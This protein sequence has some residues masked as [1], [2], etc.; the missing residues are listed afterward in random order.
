MR[1][2]WLLRVVSLLSVVILASCGG[3][4][5]GDSSLA[6]TQA[7][8]AAKAALTVGY[9]ASDSSANVTQNLTLPATGLDGST[10]SWASSDAAVVTGAGVVT[11]PTTGDKNVT[12]TATI[13][14]GSASDSK[15]F[16]LTVKAQLTE[17]EAVAAAK[18]ALTISY[19]SGDSADCVTQDLTLAPTGIDGSTLTWDSSNPVVVTSAG[20]VSRPVTGEASATLTATITVGAA[21]DTKA[22]PIAVKAQMT[23]V[24]AV[25]AAKAALG[26][27]YASGDS[28]SSVTQ[29]L[30]LPLSGI[31]GSTIGW[32][33]SD[34][35]IVSTAGAVTQ[36]VTGDANVTL[37]ATI[38]VGTASDTKT[39][40]ITVK[41]Q[42]TDAE[43]VAAAKAALAIGYAPGDASTS[44]T[45]NVTLPA[46]GTAGSAISWASSDPAIAADGGVSRPVTGDLPVTLTATISLHAASD[47]KVFIVTVKAQMTDAEAVAAA[48]EALQIGYAEGDSAASVTQNVTLP[49]TGSSAATI[50]WGSSDPTVISSD[51]TIQRPA[52]GDAQVTLTATISSH[53]V[54]D[55]ADFT[56]T[57]KGQISDEDAVAGAKAAL[58][59]GYGAGD[60]AS[61]VTQNVTLPASGSNACSVSWASDAPET[62]SIAGAVTQPESSPAVVTLIATINSHSAS[63][64]KA[65]VLT[66][67]A[68]MDDAAAVAADKTALTIGYG[69]GDSAAHVTG[70][71]VLPTSGTNGSTITWTSDSPEVISI[72]GGVT[73]PN[74]SDANVTMTA[75]ISK[76][77]ASD[78]TNF[79]LAV[80]A[81]LLSSWV[82][83]AAISP[84]NGAIEVDP[85]IVVRIPFLRALDATTVDGTAFQIA[86]TSDSQSVGATVAYD[87]PSQ[88]VSLTPLSAL[89]QDT[90]YSVIV[91]STLKDSDEASLPTPMGFSFTTLSYEDIRAQW[92]FN[93]DGSDASGNSNVVDNITGT[94]DTDI[95]HEGSASLYLDGSGQDGTSNVNLGAQLTVAVW[96]N[97]DNPIQNSINTLMANTDTGESSNG[98][99]LCI[100]RWETSDQSV[101]I[102]VGD[103]STGGK[104]TTSTGLIQPGSW[105]HLAFVIDQSHR[106]MKIYYNGVEA[107]LTFASDE[108]YTQAQFNYN[109]NTSGHL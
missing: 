21:S 42:M 20:V 23:D 53:A 101:V 92:K 39:F 32:E 16:A 49:A 70:N 54:S 97:A 95:A 76:G 43:A 24:Q 28:A 104:W 103:G 27:G 18:A 58:N 6:A 29:N 96:V 84:G 44:V 72:S 64:T 86:R 41:A 35:A 38:S 34:A 22:F 3:V 78:T 108:G 89:A 7:V 30:T 45:Q 98:F 73:V 10:I 68:L 69:P 13:S 46:T 74:D 88:T 106:V 107:P 90:Q 36:L 14:V 9:A 81:M 26:I 60:S 67:A 83:S 31:D 77:E 40:P 12:L 57:V 11:R 109:F 51:G 82:N 19:A 71:I 59:I 4:S 5:S 17:V 52:T 100:N 25:A 85:G 48:K 61:H 50:R 94:F 15:A 91:Q 47:T 56:L 65:F 62:I 63:D 99:K 79:S 8:A 37:I 55:S 102:E 66:V 75:T 87:A 80:K 1:K 2:L 93:G 33:S 105:Y